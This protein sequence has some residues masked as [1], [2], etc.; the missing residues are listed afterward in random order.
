MSATNLILCKASAGSGKTFMLAKTYLQIVLDFE[1]EQYCNYDRI[2]AVTF[3]NK[4]TEEMKSRILKFLTEISQI[5][6]AEDASKSDIAR[7]LLEENPSWNYTSLAYKAGIALSKI[8][9][10]YSQF[11]IMTI[12]KFFNR[13]VKSFLFELKLQNNANVSMES[14][15]ALDESI[16][17]MMSEYSHA[18]GHVLSK[19]LKEI[20]LDKVNEGKDWKPDNIISLLSSEIFKEHVAKLDI[21]YE[22]EKIQNLLD[23]IEEEEQ[24]FTSYLK[25][26]VQEMLDIL[27]REQMM[28]VFFASNYFPKSLLKM[29]DDPIR[30]EFSKTVLQKINSDENPFNKAATKHPLYAHVLDVW[31]S[32]VQPLAR[33]FLSYKEE[34]ITAYNTYTAFKEFLKALALLTDVSN[35]M[36]EYR[37]RNGIMLISDNN[38]LIQKVVGNTEASFLYEKLGNKFRFILLDEFQD[39]STLQWK[40]FLPLV[41]EILSHRESCKVLIVGDAKQ[42][43]YRFRGGNFQLIQS[44]VKNDLGQFW[45]EKD[46]LSVLDKNY[47]SYRD[48][49]LFNNDLFK[50]LAVSIQSFLEN[51]YFISQDVTPLHH[52]IGNLYN[53]EAL[54]KPVS[55]HT[56]FVEARFL[57][58]KSRRSQNSENSDEEEELSRSEWIE[59]NLGTT[60][61]HLIHEKG[62]AQKDIAILVRTNKEAIAVS[63]FLKSE[64]YQV[65]TS[66]ALL[67]DHHPVIQLLIAALELLLHPS[68]DLNQSAV[69]YKYAYI[70]QLTIVHPDLMD[71]DNRKVLFEK[72]LPQL[73]PE[74]IVHLLG[75]L[76]IYEIIR[77]M[78]EILQLNAF[79]D[80]Y[81]EQF[82]DMIMQYQSNA[83]QTS[84]IDFLEWWKSKG[85]SI[86]IS[87]DN[88]AIQVQT[89]H[90]S[91]GLEYK[92]VIIPYFNWKIVDTR[93][94]TILWTELH[95]PEEMQGFT[96]LPMKHKKSE[97]TFYV[98][99]FQ[100]EIILQASENLNVAYVALTRASEKMYIFSL[101]EETKDGIKNEKIGELMYHTLHQHR[102]ECFVE[103]FV[104]QQGENLPKIHS[105]SSESGLNQSL[106]IHPKE[107]SSSYHLAPIKWNSTETIVGEMIHEMIAEYQPSLNLDT[108][109]MKFAHRYH[110]EPSQ[111]DDI[112]TRVKRFFAHQDIQHLYQQAGRILTERTFVFEGNLYRFDLLILN[113][114]EGQLY[115]F[116][117]GDQKNNAQKNK[118]ALLLYKKA[119]EDMGYQITRQAFIYIDVEGLPKFEYIEN[120]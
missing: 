81:T 40:N 20:S 18:E 44:E 47:R 48:I 85:R 27:Q 116:K 19:W 41:R 109:M 72:W 35:K 38:Q 64:S 65:M 31:Y 99:D 50:K 62:Y 117:T 63:D 60:I 5:T 86:S 8:L 77:E 9:H 30:V 83:Y 73:T 3:T 32:S 89:I 119:L 56:G 111:R 24:K 82:L 39:T 45:D 107:I 113:C 92:V 114:R 104:M 120:E 69:L 105:K 55:K 4:A 52:T 103:E 22:P 29:V 108:L 87:D 34:N 6:S 80:A 100:E 106:E 91:K 61:H 43:I 115:D 58:Y 71:R 25:S 54:Q 23:Q 84:I 98:K 2:L 112:F 53:D 36:K 14:Q 102:P 78:M 10:D 51:T 1:H 42:A 101:L 28:E 79:R 46:S 7:I 21:N 95:N 93:K 74:K 13:I 17:L 11:S 67:F 37:E 88:E 59:Q 70:H 26:K 12:D 118:K 15:Q 90:K 94:D 49:V 68:V 57:K 110:F 96:H 76:S 97:G 33:D 75:A 66:E 16:A